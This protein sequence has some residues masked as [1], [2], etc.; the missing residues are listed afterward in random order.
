MAKPVRPRKV[1]HSSNLYAGT[2][3][4]L[5]PKAERKKGAS[6]S[7]QGAVKQTEVG[8]VCLFSVDGR[9]HHDSSRLLLGTTTEQSISFLI[10]EDPCDGTRTII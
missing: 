8:H 1:R 6:K 3:Q 9:L 10:R 5:Q 7:G 4:S 2:H